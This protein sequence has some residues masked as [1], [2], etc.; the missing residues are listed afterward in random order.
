MSVAG[1]CLCVCVC[2]CVCV[3]FYTRQLWKFKAS[4]IGMINPASVIPEWPMKSPNAF[5]LCY[6]QLCD[7]VLSL[8]PQ[9]QMVLSAPEGTLTNESQMW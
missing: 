9:N 2:V 3:L 1:V 5:T 7:S 4:S 8:A 6:S